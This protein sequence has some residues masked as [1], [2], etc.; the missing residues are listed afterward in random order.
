MRAWGW[1]AS[2][3]IRFGALARMQISVCVC[4]CVCGRGVVEWS[5]GG[6]VG[7]PWI[8]FYLTLRKACDEQVL[9]RFE[10]STR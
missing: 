2:T 1:R 3:P 5:V 7:S 9:R 8:P 4:V 10:A 6:G